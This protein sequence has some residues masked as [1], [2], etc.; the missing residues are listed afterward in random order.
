MT[1]RISLVML[2]SIALFSLNLATGCGKPDPGADG[3]PAAQAE[4][5]G[6]A[7]AVDPHDVPITEEQKQQ[8]R[9]ET[10]KFADAVAKVKQLRDAVARETKDGL[11][12]N[13]FEAH[14]ALDKAD[15]IVQW[16]PEIAQNS[17]VPKD[18]W[19][20]V[21][22]ASSTLRELFDEVHLNIDGKKDPGF[23]A[24]QKEMDAQI[25]KLEAVAQQ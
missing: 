20:A 13:P 10:A 14:Q 3:Q 2:L 21:A 25:A 7:E 16:L 12:S 11:L 17:G 9:E 1:H 5:A 22:T 15:I 6:Q 19:E 8:M 23:A 24:V 4:N 18:Q